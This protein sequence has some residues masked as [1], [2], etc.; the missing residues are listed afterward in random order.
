MELAD[1][2]GCHSWVSYFSPVW[3]YTWSGQC[4][5]GVVIGEGTLSES[6]G[7]VTH[8]LTGTFDQGK[9][10]GHWVLRYTDGNVWE[11]PYVDGKMHGHWVNHD[12]DGSVWEG[13]YV[14][15]M[16]HGRWIWRRADG[17][18]DIMEYSRSDMVSMSAC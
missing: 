1:K 17:G 4:A 2:L 8:A 11:G 12:P 18:C 10:H 14:D 3:K 6:N 9:Q 5:A 15:G 7:S 13:P 16:W